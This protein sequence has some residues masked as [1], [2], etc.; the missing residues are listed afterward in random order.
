MRL[1]RQGVNSTTRKMRKRGEV[2]KAV[3]IFI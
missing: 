1:M 2:R 3:L